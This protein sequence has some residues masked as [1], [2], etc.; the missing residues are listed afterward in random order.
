MN[1]RNKGSEPINFKI[2]QAMITNNAKYDINTQH[3]QNKGSNMGSEHSKD[4][5]G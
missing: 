2:Y 1:Y 3:R 4:S 5:K